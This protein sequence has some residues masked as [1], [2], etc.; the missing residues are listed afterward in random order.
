M[1]AIDRKTVS[2]TRPTLSRRNVLRSTAAFAVPLFVPA[3]VLGGRGRTGA[4]DR[5]HIGVIGTGARGK[6]L[7]ANMPP[8]GR[9]VS[10]CD[11]SLSRIADTLHPEGQFVKPL[12]EFSGSEANRCSIH[13]DYRRMVDREKLDAVMIA[14][15]DHHHAQAAL[16]ALQAELDVY[17]EKALTVT[18]PEGRAIVEAAKYHQRVVQVGTQ[19]RSMQVNR[20]ACEFVRDGGLGKVSLVEM[21]NF[22]G[23]MSYE[24]LKPQAVPESLD[25]NLFVGPTPMRAHHR[26]LWVKDHFKIGNLLWRGWDLWRDYSG[27]GMTNWGTHRVDL[28]HYALGIEDDGP[29]EIRPHTEL[30]KPSLA[31]RWKS[32]TPPVGAM[33]DRA[34]DGMRFCPVSMRYAS[35]VELRFTPDGNEAL[36]HGEHGRMLISR[37]NYT[38]EPADL[39]GGPD[40]AEQEKWKG[41]GNVARPHIQNWIDCIHT[42]GTPNAPIA[43]GHRVTSVCLLANLARELGRTLRWNPENERFVG[44]D[45]A[46][47][48]LDRPRRTGFELPV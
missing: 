44:D 38:V 39:V 9:V 5:I 10:L 6:Y 48:R 7:I 33:N 16:L 30:I 40:P 22:P 11:C 4:N 42:R 14:T 24:S 2:D 21:P 15:P 25:W 31:D 27:H 29:M 43:V 3:H 8:G 28:V 19:Q 1:P 26:K 47:E 12:A 17:V 41:P 20:F 23:P 13:Q 45:E 34:V 32:T 36:I 37:N 46:N 18:I 35:G